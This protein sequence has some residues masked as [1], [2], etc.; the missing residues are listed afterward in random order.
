MATEMSSVSESL[1]AALI[2]DFKAFFR[3]PDIAGLETIDR[4]YTQD[5]EFHDPIHSLHGRLAVKNYLRSL[6]STTRDIR[7]EYLEEQV[8]DNNATIVWHMRFRHPRLNGGQEVQVRGVTVVR[9]TDRIYYHEDFYD[10]SAML[11]QHIPVL[12]SVVRFI[13]RRLAS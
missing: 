5:V 2:K 6:Y 8:S 4:I 10:L 12:G 13:N 3:Q 9:F 11:Y 1:R 7:F